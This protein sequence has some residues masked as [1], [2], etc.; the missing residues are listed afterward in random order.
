M[1]NARAARRFRLAGKTYVKGDPISLP[2]NQFADFENAGMVSRG[3]SP[4]REV[5]A[6]VPAVTTRVPPAARP[7]RSTIRRSAAKKAD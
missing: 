3:H 6:K 7:R 1:I 4:R 5:I 2:D